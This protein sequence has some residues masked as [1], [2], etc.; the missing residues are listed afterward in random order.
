ME[1][2]CSILVKL[3]L[4]INKQINKHAFPASLKLDAVQ[5]Q[6]RRLEKVPGNQIV[7][8]KLS[9]VTKLVK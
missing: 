2:S 1:F 3:A 5:H 8:L 4:K 9:C 7:L 6:I